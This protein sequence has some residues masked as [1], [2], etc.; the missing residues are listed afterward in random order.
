MQHQVHC[1]PQQLKNNS[2]QLNKCV[3]FV[4]L[5]NF[6][7]R[8]FILIPSNLKVSNLN[9]K[10]KNTFVALNLQGAG[11]GPGSQEYFIACLSS[12]CCSI[13][14]V[15]QSPPMPFLPRTY[16]WCHIGWHNLGIRGTGQARPFLAN[17]PDIMEF[18]FLLQMEN[19]IFSLNSCLWFA[20]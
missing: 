17:M 10:N 11:P 1:L 20:Y 14:Q 8:H 18:F 12:I 13:S 4:L 15:A 6:K 5:Q 16:G 3:M 2:L 9:K 19:N 7:I